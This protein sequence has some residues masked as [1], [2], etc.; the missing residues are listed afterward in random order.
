MTSIQTSKIV[1]VSSGKGG[2]GKS[3]VA[4]NLAYAL[5]QLGNQV[6]VFDADIYGPSQCMMYGITEHGLEYTNNN[7]LTLPRISH[8]IKIISM[9][10]VVPADQAVGWR[11]S[12][13]T[14][15][16]KNLL[17]NT[18]WGDIDYLVVD[19][20]PGTGDIQ[21]ALCGLLPKARAVIVT[22]PQP[23]AVL[24]CKK[25]VELFVE[26]KISIAGIVENMSGYKCK[27]CGEIDPIFGDSGGDE[28]ASTF[29]IPVLARIPIDTQIRVQADGG[30]PAA[31]MYPHLLDIYTQ[32]ARKIINDFS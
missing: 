23:V 10:S 27:H 2:V 26:K 28:L 11:G 14:V 3:T 6:G 1:F 21:L 5:S 32:V 13:A 15:A 16:L 7:R 29:G 30:V 22:T 12:M 18:E 4:A 20:P 25:G 9:A 17:F 31:A 24:D 8:G 19:M